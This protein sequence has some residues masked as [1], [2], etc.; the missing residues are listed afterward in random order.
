M[1]EEIPGSRGEGQM[2]EED[3]KEEK[4]FQMCVSKVAAVGS[5]GSLLLGPL[6][7]VQNAF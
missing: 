1:W 4:P 2:G 6:T 5:W 3:R 7:S